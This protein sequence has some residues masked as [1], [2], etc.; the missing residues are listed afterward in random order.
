MDAKGL[1]G[2]PDFC[3]KK[4]LFTELLPWTC[5]GLPGFPPFPKQNMTSE[6]M[7]AY[8]N[9]YDVTP[10]VAVYVSPADP[11]L[12]FMPAK[13]PGTRLPLGF[14]DAPC[15]YSF[16]AQ[17][18]SGTVNLPTA[19]SDGMSNTIS[20]VERYHLCGLPVSHYRNW[21]DPRPPLGPSGPSGS[22]PSFADPACYDVIPLRLDD[23]RT[24]ASRLSKTFQVRPTVALADTTIP[25]T[26]YDGGLLVAFFDGSVRTVRGGVSESS[27]WGMVTPAGGEVFSDD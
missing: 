10:N 16:N 3:F 27:F 23:G 22:R 26:P 12:A 14:G 20:Y 5:P 1:W 17:V 18:F 6:D 25:Q 11:S 7:E 13:P 2:T 9:K 15:S 4:D 24:V 19:V 8:L 21:N